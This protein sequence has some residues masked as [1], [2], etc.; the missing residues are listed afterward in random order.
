MEKEEKKSEVR[1]KD[2][3]F[4]HALL[5]ASKGITIKRASFPGREIFLGKAIVQIPAV[6][7]YEN[8]K[9]GE[10]SYKEE[11]VESSVALQLPYS[12]NP[13]LCS[14]ENGVI[15]VGWVPQQDDLNALDWML[16]IPE[17]AESGGK[18]K[19]SDKK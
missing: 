19:E 7:E 8:E 17:N 16:C 12:N 3:T 6:V 18:L 10:K 1:V 9:T 14:I 2:L 15:N 11:L 13:T 4:G 5:Y